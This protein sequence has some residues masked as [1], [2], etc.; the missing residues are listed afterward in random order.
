MGWSGLD[1]ENAETG[2]ALLVDYGHLTEETLNKGR[3]GAEKV[4]YHVVAGG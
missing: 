2:L 1:R 4:L 3:G